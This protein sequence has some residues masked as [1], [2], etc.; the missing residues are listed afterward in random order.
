[1]SSLKTIANRYEIGPLLGRGGMGAVYQGVDLQTQEPVAIKVLRPELVYQAP[2]LIERFRREGEALQKLNHPNIVKVL[3]A[4]EVEGQP[5]LIMEYVGGGTLG[6][7]LK[8]QPRLPLE[9]ALAIALELTDALT[10]THHLNIIH[11]DIKPS[12]V[13][14]AEDGTPRLTD[15]GPANVE[16][17]RR[18]RWLP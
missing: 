3:A 7:L 9:R 16:L 17:Y 1:M 6:D 10:R 8:N 18:A 15:F 2:E 5:Y 14:L 13:L 4:L 12:N 11:R